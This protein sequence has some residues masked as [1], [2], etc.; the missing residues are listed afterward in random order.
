MRVFGEHCSASSRVRC[1]L[2]AMASRSELRIQL[3]PGPDRLDGRTAQ[4]HIARPANR[5][6]R[7]FTCSASPSAREHSVATMQ[8]AVQLECPFNDWC[9]AHSRLGFL[10]TPRAAMAAE[11]ETVGIHDLWF[12]F[13][14]LVSYGSPVFLN[15]L[16]GRTFMD[17]GNTVS[18]LWEKWS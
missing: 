14:P 2:E 9:V 8:A 16:C 13:L 3:Q 5:E 7:Q 4:R 11:Q 1:D 10:I 15:S 6:T 18:A 12:R 17:C